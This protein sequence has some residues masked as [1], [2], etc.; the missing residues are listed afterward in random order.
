MEIRAPAAATAT[1]AA[2]ARAGAPGYPGSAPP[3]TITATP[4][5]AIGL[6]RLG[7]SSPGV[8]RPGSPL[9]SQI[10]RAGPPAAQDRAPRGHARPP[11]GH[12]AP[13]PQPSR[14]R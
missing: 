11:P 3:A 10:L 12:A 13:P 8:S 6:I 9:M 1:A 2:T 7:T 5:T 4:A 14:R